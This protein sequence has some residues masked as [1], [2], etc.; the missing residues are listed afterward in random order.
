MSRTQG[1]YA[2][3]SFQRDFLPR[4]RPVFLFCY[5]LGDTTIFKDT[6]KLPAGH[7]LQ[8]SDSGDT[9]LTRYWSIDTVERGSFQGT[10]EEASEQLTILCD[11]AFAYR[12]VS[13]VPIGV[14]LSGG[15]DSTFLAA[16][17]KKRL[18]ADLEHITI[19]CT[20]PIYD[21]VPKPLLCARSRPASYG[22]T[23]RR[24]WHKMLYFAFSS[25]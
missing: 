25:G 7:Y 4:F 16:F 6:Y 5:T 3:P 11:S 12:L 15:I 20:D 24:T 1:L 2:H 13:D 22:K 19:G 17:L 8:I 21:E 23:H 14:F 18:G 10:F 9:T